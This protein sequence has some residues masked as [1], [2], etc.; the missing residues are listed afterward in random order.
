M[1]ARLQYGRQ[2]DKEYKMWIFGDP[3]FPIT[4]KL[5]SAKLYN[6]M[7]DKVAATILTN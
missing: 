1:V 2:I 4:A 3:C 7:V 5:K 6:I